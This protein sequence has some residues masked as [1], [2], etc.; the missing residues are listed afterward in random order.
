MKLA[1][2]PMIFCK[3]K[4]ELVD[5]FVVTISFSINLYLYIFGE[6]VKT[7]AG[8]LMLLRMW[9]IGEI[10]NGNYKKNHI[11]PMSLYD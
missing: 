5:A 1:L 4:W 9:R 3:S 2:M 7:V 11:I 10:A 8:L 6:E